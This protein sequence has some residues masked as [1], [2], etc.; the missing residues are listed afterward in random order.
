[1]VAEQ[2]SLDYSGSPVQSFLFDILERGKER[3]KQFILDFEQ[4]LRLILADNRIGTLTL[5][6][7]KN[8]YKRL[9]AQ[10]VAAFYKFDHHVDSEEKTRIVLQPTSS[11]EKPV[12]SLNEF[13]VLKTQEMRRLT[14][15]KIEQDIKF[16][17]SKL[18]AL[19]F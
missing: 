1:M 10:K 19:N 18:N 13:A 6:S 3:D 15:K 9:L 4:Q 12:L 17:I 14:K 7:I 16:L 8:P 5:D 2:E 11:T